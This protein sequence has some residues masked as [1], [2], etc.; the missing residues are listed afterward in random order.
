MKKSG[1]FIVFE[2][3]DGA[4]KS[5][6]MEKAKAWCLKKNLPV[7]LTREPGGCGL[8]NAIR[9]LLLNPENK[10]I[11]EEAELLLYAADRAQHVKEVILPELNQGKVVLS[12][13]YTLSTIAYQGYGRGLSI[14]TIE[15]LNAIATGGVVPDLTIVL[16]LPTE[17]AKNRIAKNREETPDR[18]EQEDDS[19]FTKVRKGYLAEAEKDKKITVVDAAQSPERI[20]NAIEAL[21]EKTICMGN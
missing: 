8:G 19:F 18:I 11:S 3:M 15:Q 16:D 7:L 10:E 14:D 20:F 2:G 5:C 6:Q 13:R 1:C 9:D 17:A 4:G 21:L 12:D